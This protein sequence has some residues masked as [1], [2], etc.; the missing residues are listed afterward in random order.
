MDKLHPAMRWVAA[1]GAIGALAFAFFSQHRPD[2]VVSDTPT[3]PL[4]LASTSEPSPAPSPIATDVAVY[5]CGAVR[6]AG[7]YHL[8][9]GSRVVDA[10]NRAGGLSNDADPEAIN[11]AS[12]LTDGMKVDIIKKGA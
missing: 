6:K 12:P 10:V 11:L 8:P 2:A 1:A 9:A 5:V 4:V 7:V 3:P